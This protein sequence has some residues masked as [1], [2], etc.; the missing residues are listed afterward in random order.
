MIVPSALDNSIVYLKGVGEKRAKLFEKLGIRTVRDLIYHLPRRYIDLSAPLPI[1][2]TVLDQP[3]VVEVTVVSKERPAMIRKG[4]TIYRLLVTDGSDDMSVTIFNSQYAFDM[5]REGESYILYGK[6][7]GSFIR[8]E[9]SSPEIRRSGSADRIEPVYPLTA[10]LTQNTVRNCVKNAL[11]KMLPADVEFIPADILDSASMMSEAEA[12]RLVHFP[13]NVNDVTHARRRLA[14]DELL[15]LRLGML[16]LREFNRRSTTF[17]MK[18][19]DMLPFF[20]ALPFQL[21][22]AQRRAIEECTADMQKSVPM[23]RLILGDVGSGKTAVAA[24]CIYFA[25]KNG[26]QSVL[27]APTEILASQH[28]DSLRGFL[29]PLGLK[30]VLL[31]GSMTKKQKAEVCKAI[32]SGA[33]DVIVGTHAVFQ[34]GVEYGQLGLVVTDEQHRFGVE[35]RSALANKG[36]NPHRIVMSATPIPRTL[37]LMIYGEL[38]ISVLDELPAGRK[39]IKTYA[40]TGKLRSRACGYVREKLSEGGQAY[41][42]CPAVEEGEDIFNVTDYAKELEKGEFKGCR[43]GVLHGKLPSAKKEEVMRKFKDG[44]LDILVCTTVVEVGVDVPNASVMMIENAD[45]FGLSQLHQLRGRVGRGERESCCI[46]IT[47]NASEET[48]KRMK[49]LG[50]TSS[51]FEISEADLEMRGPGDF[52]GSAQHGLPPIRIADL[53]ADSELIALAQDV[54]DHIT[55]TGRIT[56]PGCEPIRK[57]VNELFGQ[58]IQMN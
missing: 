19:T 39:Q 42:V 49:V 3:N 24:A 54:A 57:R 16:S 20:E 17:E 1:A 28:Y 31:V 36:Q 51:G 40:V 22:G 5:L 6:V 35:Q 13:E 32:K 33:A 50:S 43:I 15:T 25:A 44:E 10:G 41:I 23:N 37:A 27:M 34:E 18:K 12:L 47:D 56:L 38:D 14:F 2:E 46:L 11:A 52:F 30:I 4:M 53:A 21:T 45:R 55:D 26:A 58:G 9:M 48:R 8:R 7:T 29:E